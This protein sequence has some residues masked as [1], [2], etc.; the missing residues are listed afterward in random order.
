MKHHPP[1]PR[2]PKGLDARVGNRIHPMGYASFRGE[3]QGSI[4]H[5]MKITIAHPPVEG[6]HLN[7]DHSMLAWQR[8]RFLGRQ[9][10]AGS[11]EE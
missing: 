2:I 11:G 4:G 10:I 7:G 9:G 8:V 1:Y 6:A 3:Q 5:R